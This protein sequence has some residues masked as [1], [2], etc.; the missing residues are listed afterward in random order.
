MCFINISQTLFLGFRLTASSLW[1]AAIE[2]RAFL[3]IIPLS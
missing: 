2:I 3:E 1:T